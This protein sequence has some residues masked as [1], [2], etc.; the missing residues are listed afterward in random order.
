M[1]VF[2]CCLALVFWVG[3]R[4]APD[5]DKDVAPPSKRDA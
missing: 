2:F 5:D 4:L 3:Y 1:L